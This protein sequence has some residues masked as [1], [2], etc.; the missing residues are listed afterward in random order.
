M[1]NGI[2]TDLYEKR[3]VRDIIRNMQVAEQ[4][5]DDLEQEIYTILLE[6]DS[7]KIIE[8]YSKKQLKFFLV[9]VIQRQ[10]FSKTSPFYKKYTKYYTLVDENVVNKSEV[11]DEDYD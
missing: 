2:I 7:D 6:Y 1:F 11:N 9:G 3:T 8:M 10:Y 4:D 5:A